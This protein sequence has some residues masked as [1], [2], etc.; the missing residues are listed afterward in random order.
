MISLE[1]LFSTGLC[2]SLLHDVLD[3]IPVGV[4]FFDGEGKVV[5][6]NRAMADITQY[7]VQDVRGKRLFEVLGPPNT[8][9]YEERKRQ[10][11]EV[12]EKRRRGISEQYISTIFPKGRPPERLCVTA[13]P[14]RNNHG[15]VVGSVGLNS[16]LGSSDPAG[17]NPFM[18]A[19]RQSAGELAHDMNNLLGVISGYS[20]QLLR[21]SPFDEASRF[22]VQ[23]ISDAAQLASMLA[24]RALHEEKGLVSASHPV[25]LNACV[26][27]AVEI[28]AGILPK[29]MLELELDHCVPLVLAD[30]AH[31]SQILGNLIR[32]AHDAIGGHGLITVRTC[33]EHASSVH[34][35]AASDG[36]VVLSV[37]DNGI[38]MDQRVC[39]RIFDPYF[40]TKN[41]GS[42]LGLAIVHRLL[43][44]HS[45]DISVE[46]L[47]GRGTCFC[48][49]FR[50]ANIG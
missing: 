27:A 49:R 12:L 37:S 16:L 3:A 18:P 9:L 8:I 6:Y 10:L 1:S 39:A 14:L 17:L 31:V 44:L 36:Q 47:P 25:D 5:H 40:T 13:G 11:V 33:Y 23:K 38:G 15:Q 50:L 34:G 32:N 45:A 30:E 28:F 24:R 26:H 20:G 43:S 21:Q 19:T 22:R 46:S 7:P 35:A 48:A 41:G 42:G 4:A 2:G 29:E